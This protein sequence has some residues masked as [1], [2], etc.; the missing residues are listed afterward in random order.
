MAS[1]VITTRLDPETLALVDRLA[2]A[3]GRS[4]SWFAAQ[5][6]KRAAEAEAEYQAFVQEGIDAIERGEFV[7]HEVVEQM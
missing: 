7:E 4:R 6:I 1:S 2:K 3:Q 5:A